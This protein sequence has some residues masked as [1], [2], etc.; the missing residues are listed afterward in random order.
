ML[1]PESLA[2]QPLSKADRGQL[3]L[4][5]DHLLLVNSSAMQEQPARES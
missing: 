4:Q 1:N 2:F 5:L 3:W